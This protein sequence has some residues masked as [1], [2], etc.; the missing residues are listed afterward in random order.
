MSPRPGLDG[1]WRREIILPLLGVE[2]VTIQPVPSRFPGLQDKTQNLQISRGRHVL[3]IY[4]WEFGKRVTD[5]SSIT[6]DL[7]LEGKLR[8]KNIDRAQLF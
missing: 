5:T 3:A 4:D 7:C 8:G 2:H 6:C 1:F